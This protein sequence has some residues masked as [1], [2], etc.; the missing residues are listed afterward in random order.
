MKITKVSMLAVLA[1]SSL[2]VLQG[3]RSGGFGRAGNAA[4]RTTS[5]VGKVFRK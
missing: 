1:V 2:I 4:D 5:K 3:C